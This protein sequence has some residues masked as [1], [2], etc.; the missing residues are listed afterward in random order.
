MGDGD[1]PKD[2]FKHYIRKVIEKYEGMAD[3]K[4]MELILQKEAQ[5]L[6]WLA[7]QEGDQFDEDELPDFEPAEDE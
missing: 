2:G 7:A 6:H 1:E 5:R 3:H 4:E